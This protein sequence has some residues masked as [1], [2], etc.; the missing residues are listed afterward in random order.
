MI[1]SKLKVWNDTETIEVDV[2]EDGVLIT[3]LI[4]ALRF[5]AVHKDAKADSE[6]FEKSAD[7]LEL[8]LEYPEN[9]EKHFCEK[10]GIKIKTA[11]DDMLFRIKIEKLL[12]NE[13]YWSK[14]D[15]MTNKTANGIIVDEL[16][17][18]IKKHPFLWKLIFK[19]VR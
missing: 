2:N 16:G 17:K 10:Y 3:E 7:L 12:V 5:L 6:I 1:M 14:C 9:V 8:F 4:E 13:K 18:R 15:W 19:L 11:M